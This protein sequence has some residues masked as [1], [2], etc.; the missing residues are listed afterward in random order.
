MNLAF[1]T[2]RTTFHSGFGGLETQTKV[3]CEGLVS[4]GY[5]VTVFS[6]DWGISLDSAEENGVKYV[7]VKCIY[8]MG[9]VFGFFGTLQKSNWINRSYEEFSLEHKKNKF[10]VILAQSSTGLGLIRAKDFHKIPIV[11]IAH[12]SIVSEYKTFIMSMHLFRDSLLLIKNTGFFVKNFFRRQR[13]FVHGSKKIVA[14]SEYVKQ[15]L[16]DE[17]FTDEQKVLVIHNGIDPNPY[18]PKDANLK[19]GKKLLYVGQLTFSKGVDDLVAIISDPRFDRLS[20]DIVG[21]GELFEPLSKRISSDPSLS[22]RIRFVGKVPY[23]EVVTKYFKNLEYGVFVFPTK[24]YEGLPMVL[25]E[26][27]FS[28]LPAVVYN[29]GGVNDAVIDGVTGYLIQPGNKEIFKNKILDII[30]ND[31]LRAKMSEKALESAYAGFTLNIMLDKYD[32][33]IKEVLA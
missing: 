1:F 19:R 28:G 23:T 29:N 15:A 2:K 5:S 13:D 17:T 10:D 27:M 9:P 14:V 20:L 21:D 16:L 25:V 12:G 7:F 22:N 3:L 33:V 24:R 8:R 31:D 6:P 18:Y 26:S 11:S 4:K 30:N 32:K